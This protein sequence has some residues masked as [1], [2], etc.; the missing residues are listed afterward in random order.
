MTLVIAHRGA[1][2]ELRENTVDAFRRAVELG[3]DGVEL[4]VR[5]TFDDR[6]VV[7]HNAVLDDG[8]VVRSM[9][10][11][12]LPDHVPLLVDALDACAGAFVNIEIKNGRDDP[13]FDPGDWVVHR[14][15]S[16]LLGRREHQGSWLV[17]SFRA[18]TVVRIAAAMPTARTALLTLA[19]E[20]A[21]VERAVAGRHAA[22]H[23][24]VET[25]DRA[26]VARAHTAGLA[27]NTWTCNDRDRMR[28]L[29]AWG[30]D[31][32]CTDVPDVALGVRRGSSLG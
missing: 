9:P 11:S 22:I 2:R 15:V 23:P 32:I 5:R 24:W 21:D 28:E 31:G 16:E 3:A 10:A 20:T 26:G 18:T 6:L 27:V 14:L 29:I 17:S 19:C 25:L 13:D 12:E 1:S 4:D 8:R 7:H 30:V